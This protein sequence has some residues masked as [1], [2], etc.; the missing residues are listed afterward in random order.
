M[1]DIM[2]NDHGQDSNI[3]AMNDNEIEDIIN[4]GPKPEELIKI[5]ERKERK[6][7]KR[8]SKIYDLEDLEPLK[9][10][11]KIISQNSPKLFKEDN[12]FNNY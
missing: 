8:D 5:K 6:K 12:K 4:E 11:N 1:S 7:S 3:S 10:K 2:S 9:I